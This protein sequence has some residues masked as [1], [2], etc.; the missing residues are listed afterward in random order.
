MGFDYQLKY[1]QEEQKPHANSLS[2]MDFVEDKSDNDRVCFTIKN[3]YFTQSDLVTHAE[4]ETELGT[5]I[6]FQDLMK[7][8]KSGN[9]KQSS[10]AK[11]ALTLHNGII[12]RGDVAFIQ[13]KLRHLVLAIAHD[14]HLG[15]NATEEPVRMIAWWPCITQDFQHF[16]YK[17]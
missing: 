6:V 11:T 3:I 15:N 12:F 16:F 9:W 13:P 8:I 5:H 17:M 10:E 2:R 4:I 14:T 7:R 1:T